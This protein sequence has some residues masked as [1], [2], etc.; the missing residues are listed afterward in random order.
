MRISI[1]PTSRHASAP[2]GSNRTLPT[3]A[4]VKTVTARI[5][6]A[7]PARLRGLLL[8]GLVRWVG[9]QKTPRP[10]RRNAGGLAG[11]VLTKTDATRAPRACQGESQGTLLSNR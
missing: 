1:V 5:S 6:S 2:P 3:R 7:D 10:G 4:T 9:G 11:L 8:N